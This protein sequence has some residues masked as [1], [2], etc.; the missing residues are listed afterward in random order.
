MATSYNG[1]LASPRP[2]DFG[3]L[4]QLIIAGESFAPGVRAGDV[5]DVF[6]YIFNRINAEVEPVVRPDWHQADDWGFSYR[7]NTN[8]PSQISCHG[9]GTAADYNATR[10][11]NG[12]GGTWTAA[13]KVKILQ[14]LADVGNVVRVLWGY[15]EMHFEI[16][17]GVQQVSVQASRIRNGTIQ[18]GGGAP[19]PAP[20]PGGVVYEPRVNAPLGS[21]VLELGKVGSDVEFVQRWHGLKVDG[22]FGRMTEQAVRNTQQRNG[23]QVDGVVGQNTWRVMGI[24][25]TIPTIPALP[26]APRWDIP[27]GQYLGLITGPAA[28]RGG[29]TPLERQEVKWLQQALIALG[30]V[31]GVGDWRDKWADAR[32]ERATEV[33]V[34]MAYRKFDFGNERFENRIY[35]EDYETL[36]RL[37]GR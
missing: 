36:K 25:R 26:A 7:P 21:R 10:H 18:P 31:P 35:R 34:E 5:H 13:Q 23:L 37:V 11:P 3:G 33:A 12:K 17:A 8:N 1:W 30:C 20:A 14:I 6:E 32:F 19:T 28:S 15:D 24:G 9:S 4:E 27:R 29:G 2:A 16:C 22:E